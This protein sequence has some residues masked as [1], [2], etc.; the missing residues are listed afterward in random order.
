[1][2]T[3]KKS[4]DAKI[5]TS[6]LLVKGA[7]TLE[8][9]GLPSL[10][11][12]PIVYENF[13]LVIKT[14]LQ[15]ARQGTVGCKNRSEVSGS[16]KK[17]WKQK[18]TGRARAGAVTSPL[19]RGG[20]I[21]FGPQAR[22]RMLRV[23]KN[24]RQLAAQDLVR[25]CLSQDRLFVVDWELSGDTPKTKL[26]H[27]MLVDLGVENTMVNVFVPFEDKK[28]VASL[29]NI[30]WVRVVYFDSA[31]AYV[32]ADARYWVVLKKDVDAFKKMVAQWN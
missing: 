22:T 2:S 16:N 12:R 1:M 31:N 29:V 25:R 11:D 14:L 15:N 3:Q 8:T 23:S 27:Q 21:V 7:L 28:T 18:G 5:G 32:L 10:E 30:S 4:M 6:A 26:A 9:L 20:G 17:P 13:A 24:V 19:W